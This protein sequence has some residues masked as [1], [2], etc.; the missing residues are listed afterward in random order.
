LRAVTLADPKVQETLKN[1][2]V[3][4]VWDITGTPYAG[5]SGKHSVYNPAVLTTCGAGPRNVQIAIANSEGRVLLA[6]PGYWSPEDLLFEIDFAKQL[7]AVWND[8]SLS[9]AEKNAKFAEMNLAM[10][11]RLPREMISRS[12]MQGFDVQHSAKNGITDVFRTGQVPTD[13]KDKL[14]MMGNVKSVAELMHERM[15]KLPFVPL[16][17]FPI[18]EYTNYG[19]PKYDKKDDGGIVEPRAG[20]KGIG[21]RTRRF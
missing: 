11:D 2:F 6:L 5:T 4:G 3:S 17:S 16:E 19:R 8:N 13:P 9:E 1:D 10:A 12:R 18:E 21:G 20:R 14:A 15:A 7:N